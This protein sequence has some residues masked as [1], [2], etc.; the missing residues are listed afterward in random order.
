MADIEQNGD[1]RVVDIVAEGVSYVKTYRSQFRVDIAAD[2]LESALQWL[3][4][5][6][7]HRTAPAP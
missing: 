6:A 5:K 3:E 7:A 2:G 4:E 1:W